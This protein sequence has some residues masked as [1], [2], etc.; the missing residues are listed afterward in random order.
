MTEQKPWYKR[1]STILIGAA[2][3][4]V[5]ALFII[6]NNQ[7]EAAAPT[8]VSSSPTYQPVDSAAHDEQ[9]ASAVDGSRLKQFIE[10]KQTPAIDASN[11]ANQINSIMAAN[12]D[13]I[14]GVSIK[15]LN[16]GTTYNYGDQE[17]FTAA[18]TTKVLTAT[19]YLKQV[20][21]GNRSLDQVMP[22]GN[23]AQYD[24]EQMIIVS[25]NNAWHVLNE[26]LGYTQLQDYAVSIGL[27]SYYYGD[28]VINVADMTKLLADMYQRL[29]INEDH[30]QLLLSYM[31]RAN[32][33]DLIIPAVPEHDTVYHKAGEYAGNLHDATIITNSTHT[34]VLTIF[35]ASL[36]SYSKSR[37]AGLMQQMTTPTLQTFYLN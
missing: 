19:D 14:F 24:L 3:V 34:I 36:E 7:S 13:I 8:E 35:S 26:N 30:T 9:P 33:R 6:A 16:D 22:D 10:S 2:L 29:L 32:Y 28:N 25:D 12:P 5:A 17:P 37:V 18:S 31:E 15:Y 27:N 1:T 4:V 21:L 20:E 11:L 23:T